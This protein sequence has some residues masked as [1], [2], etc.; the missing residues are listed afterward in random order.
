MVTVY[1]VPNCSKCEIIK[2]KLKELNVS[3]TE[4]DY[5]KF[6]NHHEGWE[7]DGSVEIL[8]ARYYYGD[9]VVPLIKNERGIISNFEEFMGSINCK[10]EELACTGS[11]CKVKF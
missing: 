5:N 8:A 4:C 9:D 10:V 2:G 6:V 3:Y 7:E 1:S 11:E